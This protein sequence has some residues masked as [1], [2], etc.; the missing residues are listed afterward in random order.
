MT[1][2]PED[3]A[4][5]EV[6]RCSSRSLYLCSAFKLQTINEV[7][8]KDLSSGNDRCSGT[9]APDRFFHYNSRLLYTH[10]LAESASLVPTV[11]SG[12]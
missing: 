3:L 6:F 7:T 9:K 2:I 1:K 11:L 12:S 10:S 4:T 5:M 8:A